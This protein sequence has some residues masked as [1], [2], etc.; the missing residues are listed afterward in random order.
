MVEGKKP[1][2]SNN[3][4]ARIAA[5]STIASINKIKFDLTLFGQDPPQENTSISRDILWG[6]VDMMDLDPLHTT[7]GLG[8][9]AVSGAGIYDISA[10]TNLAGKSANKDIRSRV[11]VQTA[12]Y[13][14]L[15]MKEIKGSANYFHSIKVYDLNSEVMYGIKGQEI[16][17]I[18]ST[19]TF[20]YT[21]IIPFPFDYYLQ[22][23]NLLF[24]RVNNK[25]LT[26]NEDYEI[27]DYNKV[28]F[29]NNVLDGQKELTYDFYYDKTTD[30]TKFNIDNRYIFKTKVKSFKG[31]NVSK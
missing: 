31:A 18:N 1:A 19:V 13:V 2:A 25:V 29:F 26:E 30:S 17:T 7:S 22:K 15:D 9:T 5:A 6:D 11:N 10:Y 21:G 4:E 8:S 24:I 16:H 27:Y 28:R 12:D 3:L 14:N 23:G 20:E